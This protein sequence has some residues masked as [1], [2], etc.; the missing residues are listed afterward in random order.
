MA[1]LW[2]RSGGDM[3]A[4]GGERSDSITTTAAVI[5]WMIA[6]GV[7]IVQFLSQLGSKGM[8]QLPH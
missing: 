5:Q 4:T 6:T 2:E 3:R 8:S 7:D 1:A